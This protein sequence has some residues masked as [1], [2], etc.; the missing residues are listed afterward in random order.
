MG[1]FKKIII[2]IS[3]LMLI[4]FI[5]ISLI[6]LMLCVLFKNHIGLILI[7]ILNVLLT[8]NIYFIKNE[9]EEK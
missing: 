2:L 5:L 1:I 7:I 6:F 4:A 3:S 8:L 9:S